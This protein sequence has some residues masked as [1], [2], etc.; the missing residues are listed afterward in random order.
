MSDIPRERDRQLVRL[1]QQALVGA[2]TRAAAHELNNPLFVVL[3]LVELVAIALPEGSKER[4]RLELAHA[5][6]GEMKEI[7]RSL[8]D[9][10]RPAPDAPAA[11]TDAVESARATV[12]LLRRLT[13]A[14]DVELAERYPDG[15]LPVAAHPA[16]LAQ[17]L[18]HLVVNAQAAQPA[19]GA[20]SIVLE[21]AG[22]DALLRVA[23]AG[24]GI[25]PEVLA[26]AFEPLAHGLGLPAAAALARGLG[27]ELRLDAPAGGGTVATIRL[28]LAP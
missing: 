25:P 2:L 24:A 9:L 27:G 1:G 18:A 23:D 16:Q 12:A 5:T 26:S 28:P 19:G 21:R 4:E 17:L 8:L 7:L 3:G 15:P 11:P 10:A 6:G 22:G 20:V 14:K 13:L